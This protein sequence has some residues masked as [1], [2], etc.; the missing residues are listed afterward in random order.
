MRNGL[1]IFC[2][3]VILF[4]FTQKLYSQSAFPTDYFSSPVDF[5]IY[6]SAN[7]AEIRS[8]HFHSGL[9][10]KT[11]GRSGEKIMA[12]TDGDIVRIGVSPGGFGNAI[13]I[14]HPN[15]YTSVYGHLSKFS[16]EVSEYVKNSQYERKSFAVNLY[17]PKGRFSVKKGDLIGFS[18]N[19]GSSLGPHLHFEIRETKSQHPTNPLLYGFEISDN[20][21]PIVKS[22]YLYPGNDKSK[23]NQEQSKER[24]M[25]KKI[26]GGQYEFKNDSIV[27]FS[28]K[29]GVGVEAYDLLNGAGNKCGVYS[30]EMLVDGKR[31][32]YFEQ[33]EFSF[34]ET[35]YV[36]SHIDYEEKARKSRKIMQTFIDPNNRLRI[37]E[38]TLNGGLIDFK[39]KKSHNIKLVL[40]D[41]HQN[42]STIDFKVKSVSDS[43]AILAE[44]EI[45][46]LLLMPY[47]NRNKYSFNGFEIDIPKNVLYDTLKFRFMVTPPLKGS[48]SKVYHVH[49]AYTPAHKFFTIRIK[50]ENVPD[51]LHSKLMMGGV[52][53]DKIFARNGEWKDGAV[54]IKTR[55]FG[56]YLVAMDTIAPSVLPNNFKRNSDLSK[57]TSLRFTVRDDFSGIATYKGYIDGKWALFEYDPKYDRLSYTLDKERIGKGKD[58]ELVLKV[59]D[60]KK[61][62]KT[63]KMKFYW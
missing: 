14:N 63:F 11:K 20:I 39:D 2:M 60:V 58:H 17:P 55:D 32:T 49:N 42:T 47:N 35:R 28:G 40:K 62:E 7:F 48:Y 9:D 59:A 38:T 53:G 16:E 24:F 6:L 21:S 3:S 45:E 8:N 34:S 19:S 30:V 27:Y 56:T 33:N 43:I 10:I 54:E 23:I 22:V 29:M 15:G 5:R 37:Y 50:P 41:F 4:T 25:L 44:P 61:N 18:G 52:Y 31:H 57:K 51:S 12:V 46:Y 26:A 1:S 13:Y 36:N